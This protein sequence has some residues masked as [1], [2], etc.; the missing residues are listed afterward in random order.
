MTTDYN[1]ETSDLREELDRLREQYSSVHREKELLHA[2]LAHVK[3]LSEKDAA[4]RSDEVRT[5]KDI[6][7]T[8]LMGEV[9]TSCGSSMSNTKNDDRI[10]ALKVEVA[11]LTAKC[12]TLLDENT[13]LRAALES[14]EASRESLI[15]SHKQQLAEILVERA[16]IEADKQRAVHLLDLEKKESEERARESR[17]AASVLEDTKAETSRLQHELLRFKQ[18]SEGTIDQLRSDSDAR[19][20][21]VST[22]RDEL[23]ERVE[24]LEKMVLCEAPLLSGK[25]TDSEGS[26]METRERLI[27][28]QRQYSQLEHHV[29]LLESEKGNVEAENK[30]LLHACD[31]CR[32]D[33]E[34]ISKQKEALANKCSLADKRTQMHA[35]DI[36]KL[37]AEMEMIKSESETNKDRAIELE[38][39]YESVEED[40]GLLAM[41]LERAEKDLSSA[42]KRQASGKKALEKEIQRSSLYRQKAL[43][44]HERSQQAKEALACLSLNVSG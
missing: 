8:H 30:R 1:D 43:E 41:K 27:L 14:S 29:F 4:S 44:A 28:L 18:V 22:E 21:L 24:S 5:L 16:S 33:N 9:T 42:Q 37:K 7:K 15:S 10:R 39:R 20:Q 31:A 2:E 26:D 34:L 19:L 23:R 25:N 17:S 40:K 32:L 6:I 38:G 11:E 36:A 12:T 3:V 35:N 13:G